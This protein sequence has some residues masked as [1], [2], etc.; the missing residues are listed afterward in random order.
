MG[1]QRMLY[2]AEGFDVS[3]GRLSTASTRYS[4]RLH[5]FLDCVTREEKC[6]LKPANVNIKRLY[7]KCRSFTPGSKQNTEDEHLNNVT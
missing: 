4:S 1:L 3:G 5:T 7:T 2:S 6:I